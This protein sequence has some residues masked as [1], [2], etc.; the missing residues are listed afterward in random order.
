MG[1]FGNAGDQ[2]AGVITLRMFPAAAEV[3]AAV[4]G[5][6]ELNEEC[7]VPSVFNRVQVPHVAAAV[8]EVARLR[9]SVA[10][11]YYPRYAALPQA[12]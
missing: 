9:A 4:S 5:E 6:N 11:G 8:A 7:V 1:I 3:L 2:D 12:V 10:A